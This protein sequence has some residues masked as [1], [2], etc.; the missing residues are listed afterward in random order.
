MWDWHQCLRS[1]QKW[2]EDHLLQ[3]LI[4]FCSIDLCFNVNVSQFLEKWDTSPLLRLPHSSKVQLVCLQDFCYVGSTIFAREF[5]LCDYGDVRLLGSEE[6]ICN[7]IWNHFDLQQ[8]DAEI[9]STNGVTHSPLRW[10]SCIPFPILHVIHWQMWSQKHPQLQCAFSAIWPR[11]LDVV[12]PILI[13]WAVMKVTAC[14]TRETKEELGNN[15]LSC[16][17][18][19]DCMTKLEMRALKSYKRF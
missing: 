11:L 12:C 5:L 15:Y 14:C 10:M 1:C 2:D 18:Y 7:T 17:I 19:E 6:D 9:V 16:W 3:K 13:W 4:F 8:T